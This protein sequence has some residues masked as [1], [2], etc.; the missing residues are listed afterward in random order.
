MEDFNRENN[1]ISK[2]ITNRDIRSKEV[3]FWHLESFIP[4]SASDT[5]PIL[6]FDKDSGKITYGVQASSF[7]KEFPIIITDA[8]ST[9]GGNNQFYTDA[10]TYLNLSNSEFLFDPDDFPN[11]T[12]YLEVVGR[13][14]ASGD[15]AR[16]LTCQLYNVTDNVAVTSSLA[17]TSETSGATITDPGS[18]V[19]FRS[20]A[21]TFVSGAKEYIFQ[22]KSSDAGLFVD[23]Q[24]ASLILR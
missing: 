22:F 6:G 12:F 21:I 4:R 17:S 24:K 5:A 1:R 3:G 19:R 2:R 13:A 8:G 9:S 7:V 10:I 16:T 15:P 20:S 23:V 18:W 14:G 11:V